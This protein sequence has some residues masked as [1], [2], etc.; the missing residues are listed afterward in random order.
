M[1]RH[2]VL[3]Y[4]LSDYS[5]LDNYYCLEFVAYELEKWQTVRIAS[6]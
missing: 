3:D 2:G 5:M 6:H 1:M 4:V